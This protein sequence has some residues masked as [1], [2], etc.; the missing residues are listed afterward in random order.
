MNLKI[1]IRRNADGVIVITNLPD[2]DWH[3]YLWEDGNF[4]CDCNRE[5]FFIRARGEDGDAVEGLCGRGKFDVR[6]SDADTGEVLYDE[7]GDK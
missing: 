5:L 1:E 6:C 3:Q 7:L 2:W 4:S